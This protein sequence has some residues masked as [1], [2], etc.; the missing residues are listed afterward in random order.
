[1]KLWK[2]NQASWLTLVAVVGMILAVAC[3]AASGGNGPEQ[4]NATAMV[5]EE[6]EQEPAQSPTQDT[7]AGADAPPVE[8]LTPGPMAAEIQGIDAWINSEPL[9]IEQLRGK[10]VLIDFWTYTCVNCIRTFPYLKQWH[11]RYA[12]DGLVIVGV[13]TPE[14]EFEKDYDNVLQAVQDHGITWPVAQD[15]NYVAWNN[16]HNR[17]WPAKYLIDQDGVVRYTHFGEGAY[18]EIEETI[19]K[20]LEEAGADLADDALTLPSDQKVDPA[21]LGNQDAKVTPELYAGYERNVS[22]ALY[23]FEPYV[24]QTQYY[25]HRDSVAE[26]EAPKELM[27]HK[28][29][30]NGP[31]FIGPERAKH[32]RNTQDYEDYIGLKYSAKSVNAVLTSDSGEAYRVRVTMDGE[33]LTEENKGQDV[34]IGEDGE[35]FILVTEPRLYAIVDNPEYVQRK[36]LRLSSNSNGFGLFAFTFGVYQ[37]GP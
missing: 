35:S 5:T 11:S 18:A 32:A 23:G 26:F 24:V 31:W 4:G 33:Y 2:V 9:T 25:E 1:L 17:Y 3:S 37:E 21:F 14:F 13:H 27:P 7:P 28:V 10:V 34:M 6:A 29:Y 8:T 16:Y 15:N 19:R 22:A 20:L 36:V 12:D 30:F